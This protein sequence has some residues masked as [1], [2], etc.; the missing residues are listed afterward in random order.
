VGVNFNIYNNPMGSFAFSVLQMRHL[1]LIWM[2]ELF[3]GR[4]G[5]SSK[6]ATQAKLCLVSSAALIGLAF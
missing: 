5:I 6:T 2:K 1:K 3:Y 4:Q